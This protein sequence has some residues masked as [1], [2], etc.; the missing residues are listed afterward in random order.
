MPAYSVRF[1]MYSL[2]GITTVVSCNYSNINNLSHNNTDSINL[3]RKY[4]LEII[5]KHWEKKYDNAVWL[6]YASNYH[7]KVSCECKDKWQPNTN[8]DTAVISLEPTLTTYPRI[9]EFGDT[10]E[11][12]LFFTP[13]N[14]TCRCLSSQEYRF[15]CFGFSRNSDTVAYREL[16][17]EFQFSKSVMMFNKKETMKTL[18]NYAK[19]HKVSVNDIYQSNL[20]QGFYP[21]DVQDSMFRVY[22]KAHKNQLAP[23]LLRLCKERKVF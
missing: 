13:I 3:R 12:V 14:D 9:R 23:T 11:L 20:R 7:S 18:M 17:D 15:C 6:F 22:V 19:K 8:N 5:Q 16:C 2:L 4:P 10:V 1:L 21:I